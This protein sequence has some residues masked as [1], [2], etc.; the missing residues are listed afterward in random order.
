MVDFASMKVNKAITPPNFD[1][2]IIVRLGAKSKK[3]VF[4]R[5]SSPKITFFSVDFLG[6]KLFQNRKPAFTAILTAIPWYPVG[7]FSLAIFVGHAS[8]IFLEPASRIST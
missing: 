5:K 1:L 7:F 6:K 4:G 3:A 8:A 2:Y